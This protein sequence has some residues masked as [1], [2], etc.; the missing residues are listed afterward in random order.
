M[1]V[2][3]G[4]MR[5]QRQGLIT[6]TTWAI[7]GVQATARLG[8]SVAGA[9]DVNGDGYGDVLIGAPGITGTGRASL[10]LGSAGGLAFTPAWT[11]Q[12]CNV[13]H[14]VWCGGGRSRRRKW[15]R[16]YADILVG[17]P[18][19]S[20]VYTA[21]GRV[22]LYLGAAA[23]VVITPAW[24]AQGNSAGASFGAA[25]ASADDVNADGYSDFLIGAPGEGG[26][27]QVRVYL[28]SPSGPTGTLTLVGDQTGAQ[29]WREHSQR[30]RREWGWLRRYAGGGSVL[31]EWGSLVKVVHCC[32]SV[33]Q[34]ISLQPRL[35]HYEPDQAEAHLGAAVGVAGDV[36]G[37]GFCRCGR[38]SAWHGFGRCVLRFRCGVIQR[39]GLAFGVRS[40]SLE[41]WHQRRESR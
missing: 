6:S 36:N 10:Y 13:C 2:L 31:W 39:P 22:S 37:D 11:A 16:F 24:Q 25:V 7:T 5:G 19:Y 28:G 30:G 4:S 38:W 1:Q 12:K 26:V 29:F 35:W 14:T 8:T 3:L 40:I 15:R 32:F 21:Q 9:G 33:L 41:V 18:G 23:G 27:G 17:E 20:D 34:R